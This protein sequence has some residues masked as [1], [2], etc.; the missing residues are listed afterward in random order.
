[1]SKIAENGQND[2]GFDVVSFQ[3]LLGGKFYV[4]LLSSGVGKQKKRRG[5]PLGPIKGAPNR[6]QNA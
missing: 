4:K 3:M 5:A 6:L 1:M 2:E